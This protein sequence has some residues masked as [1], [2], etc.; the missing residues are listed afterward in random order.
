MENLGYMQSAFQPA[1]SYHPDK[2]VV[3]VVHV[4]DFLVTGDGEMLAARGPVSR[5][6]QEVRN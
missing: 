6:E 1:V 5:T 4:D 2:D 3:V